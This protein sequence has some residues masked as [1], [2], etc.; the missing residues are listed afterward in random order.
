MEDIYLNKVLDNEQIT[1]TL[2]EVFSELKVFHFDFNNDVPEKLDSNNPDHIFFNTGEGFDNEEFNFKISIYRTPD[3]DYDQRELYLGKVFSDKYKIRTL[4]TFIKPD[5]PDDPYYNIVFE[6]GK[7]FLADD[8]EI[9]RP[10]DPGKVKILREYALQ[11]IKFDQ[12][13]RLIKA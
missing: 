4:V 2:S 9:D 10:N 3:A 5:E 8:S 6:D 7:I 1:D 12:K 13:A 11:I